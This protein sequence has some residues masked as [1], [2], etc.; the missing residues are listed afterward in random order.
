M[1]SD[2]LAL[3]NGLNGVR[4]ERDQ[5]SAAM[6][7][8]GRIDNT[9]VPRGAYRIGEVVPRQISYVCVRIQEVWPWC[10][11]ASVYKVAN[12]ACED[13]G[14]INGCVEVAYVRQLSLHVERYFMGTSFESEC[15]IPSAAARTIETIDGSRL[16]A[17]KRSVDESRMGYS[18][19]ELA[20]VQAVRTNL[21]RSQS[22]AGRTFDL[23]ERLEIFVHD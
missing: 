18:E 13:F 1:H 12:E 22:A 3:R 23:S 7:S 16:P 10:R 19:D 8:N 2:D 11:E 17:G 4:D 9:V 6:M 21:F 20:T 15:R 5:T 14:V